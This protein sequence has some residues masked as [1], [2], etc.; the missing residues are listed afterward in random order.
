MPSF[1]IFE[2]YRFLGLYPIIEQLQ[3]IV[4]HKVAADYGSV[5]RS[6]GKVVGFGG[7]GGLFSD[8]LS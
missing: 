6:K 8:F 2:L 3:L 7:M 5:G 4:L 1:F